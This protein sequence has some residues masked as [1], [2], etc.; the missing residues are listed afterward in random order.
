VALNVLVERNTQDA[1]N[2]DE[3]GD[4]CTGKL[5]T[6]YSKAFIIDYD[7]DGVRFE[8]KKPLPKELTDALENAER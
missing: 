3:R 4:S 7:F 1:R 2:A 6:K 8:P 5:T